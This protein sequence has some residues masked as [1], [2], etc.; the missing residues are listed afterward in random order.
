M[1]NKKRKYQLANQQ[2]KISENNVENNEK[3]P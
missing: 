1:N 3:Q 2:L